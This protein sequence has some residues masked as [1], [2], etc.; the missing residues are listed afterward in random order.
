MILHNTY[1]IFASTLLALYLFATHACFLFFHQVVQKPLKFINNVLQ[2]NESFLDESNFPSFLSLCAFIKG[3]CLVK[4]LNNFCVN[5]N[6]KV[7]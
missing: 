3:H 2:T 7:Y 1:M 6:V 4:F 5:I